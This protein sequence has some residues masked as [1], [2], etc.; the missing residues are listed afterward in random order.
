MVG[1]TVGTVAWA[2]V[3]YQRPAGMADLSEPLIVAGYRALFTCSAHFVAGRPLDDILKVE[4]VDVQEHAWPLLVVD[5]AE[6]TVSA[7]DGQGNTQ[8]AAWRRGM[9]CTLLPP[10]WDAGD[11]ARLPYIE[12]PAVPDMSHIAFP[13][14]DRVALRRS[15][16]HRK[17]GSLAPVMERAFD[18]ETFVPGNVT[19]AVVIVRDGEMLA[20]RY[21]EGFGLTAGN[22]TWSTAKSISAAVMG[23]AAGE[24]LLDLDE[25]AAIPE[26]QDGQDP[27]AAITYKHLLWMSSGLTSGGSNTAA[28]Y[29][30]GQD[31]VSAATTTALEA[32]PGTRWKYANNDTLLL[33]RSLRFLLDDDAAY[34]RYPYEKLLHRIGMYHTRMEVDHQGNFIGSSQVYTTAR[35][36]ARFGVLLASDGV[37]QGERILPEGWVAFSRTPAPTRPPERGVNGYGAQFWLL[38]QHDGVPPGTFTTAGNKGQWV[39]VVPDERLVIVRTGVDP[40]GV[41]W[42]QH[43]FVAEVVDAL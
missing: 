38:D 8:V 36:L 34:L 42:E 24:G 31:A 16:L 37:W 3:P 35:D 28:I 12:L 41:R 17:A 10:H 33:L 18:G 23:I 9:G 19:T 21:R 6:F 32:E 4:L 40:Q 5:A 22:R 30:G 39:T 25:P 1:S 20:E 27:R 7:R 2:Q 13:A 11:I 29:F 15:G 43:R 14:G 26:W